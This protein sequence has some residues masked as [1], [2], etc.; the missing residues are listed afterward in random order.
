M[1]AE[2][3]V[4][5]VLPAGATA[6]AW[7]A[8]LPSVGEL[9]RL[10]E[11]TF[12]WRVLDTFDQ[13]LL[14]AGWMLGIDPDAGCCLIQQERSRTWHQVPWAASEPSWAADLDGLPCQSALVRLIGL[15]A[16]LPQFNL[17]YHRQTWI[18]V[19]A[20]P[21]ASAEFLWFEERWARVDDPEQPSAETPLSARLRAQAPK[22]SRKRLRALGEDFRRAGWVP[23]DRSPYA[24]AVESVETPW[25]DSTGKRVV[26]TDPEL[27]ADATVKRILR[28]LLDAQLRN[29]AGALAET[30]T[31]FLHDYRIAVRRARALLGQMGRVFPA[32]V[33]A[34]FGSQFAELA[35][36]TG[37]ARDW[38]VF[39]LALPH[40]DA[41]LPEAMRGQLDPMRVLVVERVRAAHDRLNARLRSAAHRRFVETWTAFLDKP[42]PRRPSAELALVPIG[43]LASRRI[44]KL[45]RRVHREGRAITDESPAE[46]LHDLRKTAKKLRYQ[47]ECF[48][49][50]YDAER[51]TLF[52]RHLK[53]LQNLLGEFQDASVQIGHLRDLA[54]VLGRQGASLDSLLAV[55]ALLAILHDD[56]ARQ[57]RHLADVFGSFTSHGHRKQFRRLFRPP[58]VAGQADGES[59]PG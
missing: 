44:W 56:Q 23:A 39:L 59:G 54:E 26:I 53:K 21:V 41:R 9:R 5:W 42:A 33:M 14:A 29:E 43:E 48:Q 19:T 32:G 10:G 35:A 50:L 25:P 40:L 58:P 52:L 12:C 27:R 28:G 30:D 49:D 37:P 36:V 18:S 55:G 1:S 4:E 20:E 3:D 7:A 16:L 8:R 22:G 38:D 47:M 31:E 45:Y 34:R 51:L 17:K 6:G 57:R 13:R 2:P 11:Q 24:E 15:R 46:A